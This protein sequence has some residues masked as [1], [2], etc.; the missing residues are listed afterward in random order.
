LAQRMVS[1]H[2][3]MRRTS[4]TPIPLAKNP[5]PGLIKPYAGSH[6]EH[7]LNS[8]HMPCFRTILETAPRPLLTASRSTLDPRTETSKIKLSTPNSDATQESTIHAL[9]SSPLETTPRTPHIASP[10]R[11]PCNSQ[12]S[13]H[14]LETHKSSSDASWANAPTITS[15]LSSSHPIHA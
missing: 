8:Q 7:R 13:S 4:S 11:E 6:S 5:T 12:N 2:G 15:V 10:S 3:V 1:S 9:H 14:R